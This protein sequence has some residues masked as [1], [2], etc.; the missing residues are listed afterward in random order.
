MERTPYKRGRELHIRAGE[1]ECTSI[2]RAYQEHMESISSMSVP[3]GVTL[4][5]RHK[6]NVLS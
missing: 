3:S 5:Q 6:K 2:S 4:K 1:Q